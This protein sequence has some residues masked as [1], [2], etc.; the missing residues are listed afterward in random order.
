MDP[1][2][3]TDDEL[4]RQ[5]RKGKDRAWREVVRRF[6]PMV[7][8]L[9][10][11]LLRNAADAEDACQEVFLSMHRSFD[12]FDASRPLRPWVARVA[13][14]ACL[15]RLRGAMTRATAA[16][17]PTALGDATAAG[18][19]GPEEE[20]AATERAGHLEEA[21]GALAALDR[22]L[23]LLRYREGLSDAE[24]AEATGM[25]VGTVKT[26][27]HRAKGRMREL[28]APVAGGTP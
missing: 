18:N 4:A 17:D 12:T 7:F 25:A 23:L 14:H 10:V 27:I 19:A 6:S 28:L 24:V 15:K 11:R 26:R 9:A 16:V 22:A 2:R 21:F 5:C 20:A 8:R 3:W 13:Y 1:T